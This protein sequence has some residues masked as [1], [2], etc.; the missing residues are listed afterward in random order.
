SFS[1]AAHAL[2][3]TNLPNSYREAQNTGEW[4]CWRKSMDE[5]LA[6]MSKYKVW[7]VV[8]LDPKMRIL[9]GRWVYTR[10]ID[11]ETGLPSTYK[12]RFVAKGYNQVEGLDYNELFAAVAHKDS[13]QVFLA[14]V[15]HFDLECDQVD[16][17]AAFLNGELEE[18]IYMQ[19]PEGSNIP[20]NKV[21]WL[22]KSLYGLKQSPRCFNKA[23]DKWLQSQGLLPTKADPC[24]YSKREGDNILMLSVHVDDQLIAC[25][26]RTMLD[27][28]KAALNSEFECSDSGPVGYFLGFNIHRDRTNHK[29]FMSQEHYFESLLERFDLKDCNPAKTPLPSGFR[30]IP[31]TDQE[32]EEA[33]HYPYAQ[34]VGAILY[35]STITRPDLAFPASLL[36]RFLS[37][38]NDSHWKAVKH[39]LRYIRGTSDLCLTFNKENSSRIALGYADADWGGDLDTRRSTTGYVFKVYGGVVAWKSRRQPT[40]ALSTTEAEYMA[41]SDATRQAVWLRQ[42]LDDLGLGLGEEPLKL[43]NDN[44]ETIALAKN[45]VHHNK[46]KHI[47]LRHHYIREKV[48]DNTVSLGHVPSAENIA[49]L[50]TKAL[51]SDTFDR[52]R[53][54]LGVCGRSA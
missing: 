39:L 28:F 8:D 30:P 47:D 48:E 37:K 11:G 6:K 45:P 21:L 44:A 36:S 38:W 17:K 4:E 22:R 49:D 3:A 10:K 24:F 34:A 14:I 29:L 42:L 19:P 41:S 32:H 35:A 16:I 50:L 40:V 54:L 27:N 1:L 46:T 25:N 33:K 13:I 9:K 26:N 23:L 31:A 7:E 18:T 20:A 5:E 15:N 43:L 51:P 53:E 12:A 2:A 52:L